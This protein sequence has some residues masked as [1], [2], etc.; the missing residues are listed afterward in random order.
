MQLSTDAVT[1][2]G[3]L[4]AAGGTAWR[5]AAMGLLAA[6]SCCFRFSTNVCR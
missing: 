2:V 6:A 3:T 5:R 4:T 1:A